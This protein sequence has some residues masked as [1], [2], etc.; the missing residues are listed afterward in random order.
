MPNKIFVGGL[1]ITCSETQFREYFE[2]FGKVLKV[3]FFFGR[4][5]GYITY[6]TAQEVRQSSG[7]FG[8]GSQFRGLAMESA[9]R[10]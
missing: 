6:N 9:L 10:K 1:P 3:E 5:F 2:Q 4:C 7:F 8:S